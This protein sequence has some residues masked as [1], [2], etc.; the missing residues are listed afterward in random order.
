MIDHPILL[1]AVLIAIVA[2]TQAAA[3]AAL[4]RPL[5]NVLPVPFWCYILPMLGTSVGWLP[6]SS[7]LYPWLSAQLLPICLVLLLVGTDLPAIGR[8]GR[9]AITAMLTGSVGIL[10]GAHV[11]LLLFHRWLPETAWMGLG[12]LSASW[13]GGSA[14]MLAVRESLDIPDAVFA[15]LIVV[16]ATLAYTWMGFLI[17]A[18]SWQPR[19][20]RWVNAALPTES[21]TGIAPSSRESRATSRRANILA[22]TAGIL[23]LAVVL[24]ILC[25]SVAR[26]LPTTRGIL[27]ASTWTILL[28]T[29]L[30][31]ALSLTPV[32][33]LASSATDRIGYWLLFLLLTSV[34]ARASLAAITATPAWMAAGLVWILIHAATLLAAG[35][36]LR[37]PLFLLA[38][39]SQANI[40]GPVSAPIVAAVYRPHLASVGLLMALLGNILGTYLGLLSAHLCHATSRLLGNL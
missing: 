7:S 29:T 33:R 40:G 26:L 30:S 5:L 25:Q 2:A 4:F 1:A 14:N 24:S 18:S 27:A 3:H 12:A 31:L 20:D 28:T 23:A 38:T 37:M 15:P 17:A 11:A 19:W 21:N 35:R 22:R 8:L 16:D 39:A 6:S 13:T 9:L 34:G 32:R 36:L 10:L